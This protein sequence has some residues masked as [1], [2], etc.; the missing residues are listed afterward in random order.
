MLWSDIAPLTQEFH[1]SMP[2][3]SSGSTSFAQTITRGCAP[4]PW[5]RKHWQQAQKKE[6]HV[7]QP[8]LKLDSCRWHWAPDLPRCWDNWH[9][10]PTRQ[11]LPYQESSTVLL[12]QVLGSVIIYV[13]RH[14]GSSQL[15]VTATH[16][17]SIFSWKLHGDRFLLRL[18]A[19]NQLA[20]CRGSRHKT[21]S[22]WFI[23]IWH[24][25]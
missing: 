4:C 21:R 24:H 8:S 5:K 18:C 10:L 7:A 12:T 25:I 13:L 15:K 3:A 19:L 14:R 2:L 20:T 11:P 23:Y 17:E 1:L 16:T 22:L 9:T 6:C